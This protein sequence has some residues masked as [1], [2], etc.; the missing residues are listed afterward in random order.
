MKFRNPTLA[1]GGL[2][3][4]LLQPTAALAQEQ[5]VP[6]NT[7]PQAVRAAFARAYPKATIR[8]CAKEIEQGRTTYEIASKEGDVG[9]DVL[10][11][12]DGSLIVVEETIT[13]NEIP[14]PVHQ[15]VRAKFPGGS[16]V[17]SEKLL[18]DGTVLYEFRVRHRGKV[19]EVQFNPSGDEVGSESST[20]AAQRDK[21]Q[22]ST[23]PVTRISDDQA[24]KIA[25]GRISGTVTSVTIERKR[26]KNVYV[27]EIQTPNGEKDVLVDIQSGE[28]LGTE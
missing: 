19:T 24:T 13:I 14:E 28:V 4:L 16:I 11:Q 8:A 1:C 5:T 26:G 20:A 17:R 12:P 6:C 3:F 2:M 23:S 7:V 25:L 15:A 27:V 9:R 18:R 22:K 21:P 10:Y